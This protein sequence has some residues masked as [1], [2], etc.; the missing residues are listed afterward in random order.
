MLKKS[1]IPYVREFPI[2]NYSYDFKVGKYL[3]EI[4]PYATHNSSW[5][6]RNNPPKAKGYHKSKSTLAAEN[7][8]FC[9]HVFDWDDKEK[10]INKLIPLAEINADN[11]SIKEPSKKDAW[12]F[13]DKYHPQNHTNAQKIIGLYKD[14]ELVE[15]MTFAKPRYNSKY[16]WE[17]TRV[18]AKKG[19]RIVGGCEKILNAFKE[20]Y[21]PTDIL[22]YCDLAKLTGK[23][24]EKLGFKRIRHTSPAKHWYN[25]KA[26]R[27]IT[28]SFLWKKGFDRLFGTDYGKMASNDKLMLEHGFVEI[29]DCGQ[30]TYVWKADNS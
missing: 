19:M 26:H 5:G 6:I 30:A 17:I 28:E 4:D 29:Y 21:K 7:G 2:K 25:P 8:Y 22:V 24:Y 18:C 23:I 10:I 9:I 11:C 27:H 12:D 13:L 3:I 20:K 14:D 16:E 15:L 1:N